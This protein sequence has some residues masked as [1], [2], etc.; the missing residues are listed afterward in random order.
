MP[1][2]RDRWRRCRPS[3]R[4][5]AG[6]RRCHARRAS[7]R[8]WPPTSADDRH[9]RAQVGLELSSARTRSAV[10]NT[11]GL[12]GRED[13]AEFLAAVEVHDRHRRRRRGTPTP[14][15]SPP[16]PSSSAAG[17]RRRRRVRTPRARSPAASRR[18][19]SST[20]REGAR[21]RPDGGVHAEA[22]V[23]VGLQPVG[24]EITERLGVHH[25]SSS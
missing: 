17:T 11:F 9:V 16:L 12:R 19:S 14:R 18:A 10:M 24:E 4:R 5:R 2:C 23:G 7:A 25:P 22:G 8:R 1:G 3:V 21:V 20:S 6:R 15:T 13:V